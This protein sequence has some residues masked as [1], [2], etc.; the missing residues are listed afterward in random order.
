MKKF[1]SFVKK[2][3]PLKSLKRQHPVF[4]VL[5]EQEGNSCTVEVRFYDKNQNLVHQEVIC[6]PPN[7]LEE[8]MSKKLNSIKHEVTKKLANA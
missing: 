2:C 4:W 8:K 3:C 5:D 6:T 7:R 1:L